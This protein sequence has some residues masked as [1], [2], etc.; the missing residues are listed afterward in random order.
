[1]LHFP[2]AFGLSDIHPTEVALIG[3]IFLLMMTL[4][5]GLQNSTQQLKVAF[6]DL[7]NN[8]R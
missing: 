4:S 2:L 3:V 5:G 7:W 1:M 6:N 8:F